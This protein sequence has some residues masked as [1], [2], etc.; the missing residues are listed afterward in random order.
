MNLVFIYGPPASG[1]LTVA[2]ELS[3]LTGLPVFHNHLTRDIVQSLYPGNLQDNYELVNLLREDVL[4]YCAVH[5]TSLIFTFV[6]DGP[7]DDEVVKNRVDT[8]TSNGGNVLF[9]ELSAP[10]GTLLDRVANDSRK[11]HKKLVDRDEL[12]AILETT[13]YPSIPYPNILKIDTSTADPAESARRIQRH[14]GI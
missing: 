14:Y 5:D 13:P 2:N 9:V 3:A 12:A 6:Y 1:K 8:V 10:N 11:E 7:E 4:K